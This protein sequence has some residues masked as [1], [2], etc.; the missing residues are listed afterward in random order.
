MSTYEPSPQLFFETVNA[1]QQTAAIRAAIELGVFT[2][3]AGGAA[4]AAEL[5]TACHASERGIRILCDYLTVRG[6]LVKSGAN[7][8]LTPDSA[9]FL[10]AH[11]P[12]YL[13]GALEFLLNPTSQKSFEHLTDAVRSGGTAVPGERALETDHPMWAKFA[14]AMAPLMYQ[15]AQFIAKLAA[16]NANGSLKVLDIAAGHGAFGVAVAK[17]CPTAEIVAQDWPHVLEVAQENARKAGLDGRHRLLPGNAF[18]VDFGGPYDIVLL[19]NFL[20]HFDVAACES[21]IRKISAALKP[22]GR[23]ITLEFVPNEDRITP[24]T[25]AGFSLTMLAAT[26]AGDAYTRTEL[27]RMF[28]NSG[29]TRNVAHDLPG[30]IQKVIVSSR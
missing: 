23:V 14:R 19:T 27:E 2:A 15:P 17:E 4:T 30:G 10:N 5:A 13:G 24:S 9:L 3:S 1:Y 20:H 22:D 28:K 12:A 29:F 25:A 11:S 18:D 21:L 7:Y 26:P 6:F 16:E 8:T